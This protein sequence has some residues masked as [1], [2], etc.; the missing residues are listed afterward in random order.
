[1][2]GGRPGPRAASRASAHGLHPGSRIACC[3]APLSS[4]HPPLGIQLPCLAGPIVRLLD[5]ETSHNVGLLA[6]RLGLFPKVRLPA[7]WLPNR[8]SSASTVQSRLFR[9]SRNKWP[10][11]WTPVW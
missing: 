11:R 1:M 7:G 8:I 9:V 2:M 5:A 10:V 4:S 6:A 3:L